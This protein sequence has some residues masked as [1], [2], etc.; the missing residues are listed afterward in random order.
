[1]YK[2]SPERRGGK[3][4]G[5]VR[6]QS[7]FSCLE[8][9]WN[10]IKCDS[11]LL[12]LVEKCVQKDGLFG[13]IIT[14]TMISR[15]DKTCLWHQFSLK[16]GAHQYTLHLR[17]ARSLHISCDQAPKKR[18]RCCRM[19]TPANR[20]TTLQSLLVTSQYSYYSPRGIHSPW[21]FSFQICKGYPDVLPVFVCLSFQTHSTFFLHVGH[22]TIV[23]VSYSQ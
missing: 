3:K 9:G 21:H 1:M 17:R 2:N 4:Q 7:L 13:I 12:V 18:S 23:L 14:H 10:A 20:K 8:V 22:S 16:F 6:F 19:S 15:Q 11:W 5:G